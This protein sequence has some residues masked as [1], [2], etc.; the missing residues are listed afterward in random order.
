MEVRGQLHTPRY[1]TAV[2]RA[3]GTNWIGGWVV[4]RALLDF[5]EKGRE[6]SLAPVRD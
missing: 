6:K 5:A 2:E 3:P 4:L 1:F